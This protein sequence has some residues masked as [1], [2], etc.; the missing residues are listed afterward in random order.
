MKITEAMEKLCNLR[1]P[2]IS[3]ERRCFLNLNFPRK[4]TIE[5]GGYVRLLKTCVGNLQAVKVLSL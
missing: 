2:S 1:K 4:N 3:M 5:N